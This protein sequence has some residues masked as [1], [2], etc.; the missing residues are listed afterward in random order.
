MS[1]ALSISLHS[2]Q[3][4]QINKKQLHHQILPLACLKL[5]S[6]SDILSQ[7]FYVPDSLISRE[8]SEIRAASRRK[9]FSSLSVGTLHKWKKK[10]SKVGNLVSI[11]YIYMQLQVVIT[12]FIPCQLNQISNL[13]LMLYYL[14][15]HTIFSDQNFRASDIYLFRTSKEYHYDSS[16]VSL[17]LLSVYF[18]NENFATS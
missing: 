5:K 6:N 18:L 1:K 11:E 2:T 10:F 16:E 12:Y 7:I 8:T 15:Q 17:K 14:T 13:I 3:K 4:L 9:R